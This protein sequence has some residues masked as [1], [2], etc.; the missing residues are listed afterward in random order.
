MNSLAL[1]LGATGF[2]GSLAA[3]Y[4]WERSHRKTMKMPAG[5]DL[6]RSVPHQQEFE[7]YQN[8]LSLCARKVRICLAEYNI[9][10]KSHHIDLIETGSYEV[11]SRRYLT[12]NPGGLVPTLVHNGHPV[13]E[14]DFIVNYIA[15]QAA[16]SG[17]SL[18]P[19][20][21]VKR[22]EMDIWV[23]RASLIG[24]NAARDH[25]I[26]AGQCIPPLTVPLFVASIRYIPISRILE[27]LL[28]HRLKERAVFFLIF[29]LIGMSGVIMVP[30]FRAIVR[31]AR[32]AMVIHLEAL[33]EQLSKSS[34]DWI[35]GE[36]FT[37][38]DVTWMS[39]LHRLEETWWLK[40]FLANHQL[41]RVNA[42]WGRLKAR[43]SYKSQ[44][45]AQPHP[46][47]D[48]GIADLREAISGIPGWRA[49]YQGS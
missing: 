10:Y 31:S 49:L 36:Q 11:I 45:K 33:E 17:I 41:Q 16:G 22:A 2:V 19:A 26:S 40:Y 12:I 48:Q 15:D 43:E 3:W 37:L 32:D 47:I 9:L 38:A 25:Q 20:D 13:Y 14:S 35:I 1:G 29:K 46:V 28:F 5:I 42:Y 24:E 39:L 27:G 18:T 8:V 21:P 6:G 30:R 34:A 7:L 4:A 23:A 44:I